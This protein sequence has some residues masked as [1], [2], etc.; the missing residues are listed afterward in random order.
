MLSSAPTGALGPI[1]REER[2]PIDIIDSTY[3]YLCMYRGMSVYVPVYVPVH[4]EVCPCMYRLQCTVT[5]NTTA[6]PQ[7]R[8]VLTKV[9]NFNVLK[10]LDVRTKFYSADVR[11]SSLPLPLSGE[12]ATLVRYLSC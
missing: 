1:G 6:P 7:Q 2:T 5:Y 10:P 3:M 12:H 9:F 11:I 8:P 4:T